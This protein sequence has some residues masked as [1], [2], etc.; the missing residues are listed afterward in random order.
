MYFGDGVFTL[1]PFYMKLNISSVKFNEE[2]GGGAI[3]LN[4]IDFSFTR[5]YYF[6]LFFEELVP[7]KPLNIVFKCDDFPHIIMFDLFYFKV[8]KRAFLIS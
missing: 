3:K 5:I 1:Y 7:C 8:T 6:G 2:C 4:N